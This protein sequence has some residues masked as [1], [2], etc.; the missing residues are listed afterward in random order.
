MT[1]EKFQQLTI[2]V[3]DNFE[4]GYY[5]PAMLPNFKPADQNLLRASGE[6]MFGLDRKAGSQLA[7]YPEWKT[8]WDLLDA[9][10]AAN[11]GLWRYQYR[12]GK[13]EYRLKEL[14]AAIMFKWFTY[15]SKKYIL[16]GSMDEIDNDD[17]LIIHF[18]YASWNGE[19]WFQKYSKALN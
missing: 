3:I 4:G 1:L 9:D 13:L 19:G 2:V 18:S 6:T 12:G 11:K 16:I 5:H 14:A 15:L 17:R 7:V 10:R 8:F